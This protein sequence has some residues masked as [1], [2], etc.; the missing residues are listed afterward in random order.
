M[1]HNSQ[2][3]DAAQ[4]TVPNAILV[5]IFATFSLLFLVP[6]VGERAQDFVFWQ[7]TFSQD[8]SAGWLGIALLLAALPIFKIRAHSP[9]TLEQIAAWVES[10]P[11]WIAAATLPFYAIFAVV[12]AHGHP[13]VAD[14]NSVLQQSRIFASGHL[15]G[16]V[17]P[18]LVDWMIRRSYQGY[19]THVSHASGA[20]ASSYWPGFA[21]LLAP[22]ARLGVPWLCNPVLSCLTLWVLH[23]VTRL[24]TGSAT[25]ALW[26]LVLALASPVIAL[27]AAAYFSMPA[28]LLFNLLFCW[29]LFARTRRAAL[30]AGIIGGFALTLH[31]PV[32]HFCFALP[33]VMWVARSRRDLLAPLLL[34]YCLLALPLGFGWNSYLHT[35]D[36]PSVSPG[37]APLPRAV[38]HGPFLDSLQRVRFAFSLPDHNLWI[39]RLA[40]TCKLLIW[41]T[42]GLGLLAWMGALQSL[43]NRATKTGVQRE[44]AEQTRGENEVV[45][46]QPVDAANQTSTASQ[47]QP[48]PIFLRLLVWSFV[49][50]CIAYVFVPFE[51]GAG[52]GFRYLHSAWMVLPI[53]AAWFL[54]SI[55][56]PFGPPLR[57][58]FLGVSAL[59]LLIMV[60]FRG[61]QA[62]RFLSHHSQQIPAATASPSLTFIDLKQGYRTVD[63]VKND[64][65]LR[66]SN[67]K[68]LHRG[69][70]ADEKLARRILVAPRL[71]SRGKWGQIWVGN[72]F[73]PRYARWRS[74]LR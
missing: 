74:G 63:L 59:S 34:G 23:R 41:A 26:A 42:P 58:Y 19:A 39:N 11:G 3:L 50:T 43:R 8:I 31:N 33:W 14:E 45:T 60:P 66:N 7:L 15:A 30:L 68:F 18:E 12:V 37:G 29:L 21:L 62:E 48:S 47:N 61:Y 44:V 65:F 67:W 64:P 53:L 17:P 27:N 40:G 49:S 32:P 9:L 55:A 56:T 2:R 4:K 6:V 24:F 70:A 22:F 10:R 36:A 71:E 1:A 20:L 28:H 5:A 46:A 69:D 57:R 52:W 72:G 35:F 73:T 51:Q 13:F 25:A 54:T 38:S 16:A